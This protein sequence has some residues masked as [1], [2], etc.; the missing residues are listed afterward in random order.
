MGEKVDL[1][2]LVDSI[3]SDPGGMDGFDHDEDWK[4]VHA[5]TP[6]TGDGHEAKVYVMRLPARFWRVTCEDLDLDL[7]TGSGASELA[8]DI[9]QALAEGVL[10]VTRQGLRVEAVGIGPD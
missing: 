9:A 2:L 7:S 6:E 4:L 3:A 10:G 5:F 8:H 1:E